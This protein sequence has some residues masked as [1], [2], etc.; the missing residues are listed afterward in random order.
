M[1]RLKVIYNP[2][3]ADLPELT[4]SYT[5]P[6][7]AKIKGCSLPTVLN[8][9]AVKGLERKRVQLE[10]QRCGHKW[11]QRSQRPKVCAK[12]STHFWNQPRPEGISKAL[13]EKMYWDEGKSITAIAH[14]LNLAYN[15]VRYWMRK[16]N[17]KFR[18]SVEA[19]LLL[20]DQQRK[21]PMEGKAMWR[22]GR[23]QKDGYILVFISSDDFFFPMAYKRS[24]LS[25]SVL[26]HRL[27]MAKHLKRCLLPWEVVH[28]RNGIKDDNRLENL[29]LLPSRVQHAPSARWRA[30]I[31]KRDK[32]IKQLNQRVTLLEAE[33]VLLRQ[34]LEVKNVG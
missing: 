4:S 5:A 14:E 8:A 34:E 12:C 30:E 23:Q 13:L 17:I 24:Q 29:E 15:T 27:V 6:E 20:Y 11:F 28:H 21:R 9:L 25:G 22:Q 33:T 10:C 7:I 1:A 18:S 3:W 19:I 2:K 16:H 26:E 31:N 32:E